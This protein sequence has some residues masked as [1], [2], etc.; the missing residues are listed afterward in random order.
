MVHGVG[1]GIDRRH[2]VLL[3]IRQQAC[4]GFCVVDQNVFFVLHHFAENVINYVK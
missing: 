3:E 1:F 4:Q 2:V